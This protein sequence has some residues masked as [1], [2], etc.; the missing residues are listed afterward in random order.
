MRA[1]FLVLIFI[2]FFLVFV[3]RIIIIIFFFFICTQRFQHP[4]NITN[5]IRRNPWQRFQQFI[6]YILILCIRHIHIITTIAT[7]SIVCVLFHAHLE[8]GQQLLIVFIDSNLFRHRTQITTHCGFRILSLVIRFL[9]RSIIIAICIGITITTGDGHTRHRIIT[10]TTSI[11]TTSSSTSAGIIRCFLRLLFLS[12]SFLLHTQS[13]RHGK[14]WIHVGIDSAKTSRTCTCTSTCT[15]SRSTT[16]ITTTSTT[17]FLTRTNGGIQISVAAHATKLTDL[18]SRL[19]EDRRRNQHI[20]QHF[21]A[22]HCH[23][24]RVIIRFDGANKTFQNASIVL[25]LSK[26]HNIN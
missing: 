5:I 3:L 13:Q 25:A 19:T 22:L 11:I 17:I 18:L 4:I 2:V 1:S 15:T 6:A 16:R 8:C 12:L 9:F 21:T 14:L 10:S 24:I 20:A 7:I 26:I 23:Q